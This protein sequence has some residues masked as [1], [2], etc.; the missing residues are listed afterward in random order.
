MTLEMLCKLARRTEP[1]SI[2][3][4]VEER[5]VKMEANRVAEE[6]LNQF[7]ARTAS[8]NGFRA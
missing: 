2:R 6:S 8:K 7:T 3:A 1:T 5:S 4:S